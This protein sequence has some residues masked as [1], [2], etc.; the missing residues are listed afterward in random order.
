M[1]I[2]N[3]FNNFMRD[4]IPCENIPTFI[5]YANMTTNHARDTVIG[6]LK[7]RTLYQYQGR[8]LIKQFDRI[9]TVSS[10]TQA[11]VTIKMGFSPKHICGGRYKNSDLRNMKEPSQFL[12]VMNTLIRF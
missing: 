4:A 8:L 3:D 10:C 2:I 9:I 5:Q 12:D 6:L 11:G 1:Q 7:E